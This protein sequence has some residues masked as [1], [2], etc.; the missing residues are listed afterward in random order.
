MDRFGRVLIPKA[1]RARLDLDPGTRLDL[2]E[3]DG[4]LILTPRHPQG[5]LEMRG[6]VLVYV[7]VASGDLS[8]SVE[9]TR[10]GRL[11]DLA[12]GGEEE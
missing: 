7:G 2:K 8:A 6:G 5:S 12:D 10:S 1:L 9:G 4:A 3:S 11:E